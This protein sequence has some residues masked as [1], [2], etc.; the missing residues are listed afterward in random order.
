MVKVE[1]I[2]VLT[3]LIVGVAI[4]L[5]LLKMADL[6][7]VFTAI[8][9]INPINLIAAACFFIIASTFVAFALYTPLKSSIQKL[10]MRKVVMASF[11]G[12]LLSDVTPARS[13]YFLTP[14]F[15][16]NLAGV[17]IEQGMTGVLMTGGVNSIIKVLI[18]I[19]GLLYFASF[20]TVSTEIINA[21]VIGASVLFVGGIFI[22]LL[23]LDRRIF[24][25]VTKFEKIPLIGTKLQSFSVMFNNI[26]KEGQR[27]KSYFISVALFIFLS[28]LCNASALYFIFSGLWNASSLNIFDFLFLASIAS[29]FTY[30]P[31]TVA[32][33]G[34]QE[35]GYVI[36]LSLLLKLPISAHYV[37]PSL[38]AFA[39]VARIL[40]TGTD[41][42][43]VGP[44]I[45]VMLRSRKT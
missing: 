29:V 10:S 31:I 35:T 3:Q 36:L 41:I 37:S 25:L 6:R 23:L 27:I 30:V 34:V 7:N 14:L 16:N 11:A 5:W 38:V 32:G 40:F 44:L 18:C 22:I 15:L 28:L 9:Q 17:S 2:R 19:I 13:G 4:L 43:G 42:I 8:L 24:N 12:Q 21:S 20:Y 1:K 33:I 39:L 26:Q 45:T